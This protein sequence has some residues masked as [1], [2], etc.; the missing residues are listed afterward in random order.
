MTKAQSI[1]NVIR[2]EGG[3]VNNPKDPGG[4]TKFGISKRAY[5]TMDIGKITEE[6]ATLIYDRDY[7]QRIQ[8]DKLPPDVANM[9]LDIAVNS[10]VFRAVRILQAACGV[11]IDGKIGPRTIDAAKAPGVLEAMAEIRRKFYRS[12]STF[13]HFGKGWLIRVD[14]VLAESKQIGG[15]S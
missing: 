8:G 14:Q 7:W 4:E 10:G 1:R 6:D 3:Y 2:H 11:T 13:E 15:K 5:P 12:L 9:V